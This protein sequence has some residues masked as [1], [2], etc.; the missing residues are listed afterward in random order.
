MPY[1]HKIKRWFIKLLFCVDSVYTPLSPS[2]EEIQ[3]LRTRDSPVVDDTENAD[4]N[5]YLHLLTPSPEDLKR[6]QAHCDNKL[7][8]SAG[9]RHVPKA[10]RK[11]TT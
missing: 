1:T 2:E 10:R 3:D 5:L 6:A 11:P 8:K 4:N 7:V 9:T